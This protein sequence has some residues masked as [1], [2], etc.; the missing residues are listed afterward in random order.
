MPS[1]ARCHVRQ[2]HRLIPGCRTAV[3]NRHKHLTT[4]S[5]RRKA[6]L[7]AA[8][9]PLVVPFVAS[10]CC[11]RKSAKISNILIPGNPP[12]ALVLVDYNILVVLVIGP[13]IVR[14][15]RSTRR[16]GVGKPKKRRAAWIQRH[17]SSSH[18]LSDGKS[19]VAWHI[20]APSFHQK[21]SPPLQSIGCVSTPPTVT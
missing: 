16:F 2:K 15:R 4:K 12:T 13:R 17:Q 18:G 10:Y 20:R 14:R 7:H 8:S 6:E 19:K 3:P 11:H 1:S 5:Q 9:S 21:I